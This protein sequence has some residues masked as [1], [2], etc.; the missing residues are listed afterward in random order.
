M[1][2]RKIELKDGRFSPIRRISWD[3]IANVLSPVLLRDARA[4]LN[5]SDKGKY[6]VFSVTMQSGNKL[7]ISNGRDILKETI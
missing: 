5:G 6:T 4:T 3:D 2:Y 7:H 1:P